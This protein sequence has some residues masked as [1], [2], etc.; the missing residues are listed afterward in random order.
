MR[1]WLSLGVIAAVGGS[2]LAIAPVDDV[3]S[4]DVIGPLLLLATVPL[5]A[6]GAVIVA[7]RDDSAGL[8]V[9]SH[10]FLEWSVLS[11]GVVLV[12][13]VVVAGVGAALDSKT[14]AVA[15]RGD[16]GRRGDRPRTGSALD[17]SADRSG[18]VRRP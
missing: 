17:P 8:T 4:V 13:T 18:G 6:V 7:V 15:P 16:H 10:R 9:A 1:R 11:A 12:Y 3:P 14:P 2:V 5:L